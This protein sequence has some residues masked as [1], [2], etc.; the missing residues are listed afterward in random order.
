[1]NSPARAFAQGGNV[2]FMTD[3]LLAV[4][5]T[6]QAAR[7][8]SFVANDIRGYAGARGRPAWVLPQCR[9]PAAAR[10]F[11]TEFSRVA[12]GCPSTFG[13]AADY[14]EASD[15]CRTGRAAHGP[16]VSAAISCATLSTTTSN[17]GTSGGE[18]PAA[19]R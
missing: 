17:R 2:G 15:R 8:R 5:K 4:Y 10:R 7:L 16:G 6:I 11:S 13:F 9:S 19:T 12:A 14:R 3:D 1:M 18:K